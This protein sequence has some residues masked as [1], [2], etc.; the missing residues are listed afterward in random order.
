[1]SNKKNILISSKDSNLSNIFSDSLENYNTK[2]L[3][4]SMIDINSHESYNE[5]LKGYKHLCTSLSRRL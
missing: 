5:I 2:F 3:D 1:M 4:L